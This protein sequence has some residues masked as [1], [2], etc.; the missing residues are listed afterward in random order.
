MKIG[1]FHGEL[2]LLLPSAFILKFRIKVGVKSELVVKKFLI[3]KQW[4]IR[5]D[6]LQEQWF[7]PTGMGTD[8]IGCEPLLLELF[9]GTG[10]AF[11]SDDLGFCFHH[12]GMN[13]LG[14]AALKAVTEM[15][16]ALGHTPPT[17]KSIDAQGNQLMLALLGQPLNDMNVLTRKVLMNEKDPH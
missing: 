1:I 13:T 8:Q 7:A 16:E 12:Q 3:A 14:I 2:R 17:I 10:A 6:R 15:L 4:R 5:P 9:S 11:R